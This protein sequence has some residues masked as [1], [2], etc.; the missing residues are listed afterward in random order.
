MRINER[1]RRAF[2]DSRPNVLNRVLEDCAPRKVTRPKHKKLSD[3][4]MQLIATAAS[5]AI[6]ISAA[7][8]GFLYYRDYFAG[9]SSLNGDHTDATLSTSPT[10]STDPLPT[11]PMTPEELILWIEEDARQIIC[12]GSTAETLPVE[13]VLDLPYPEQDQLATNCYVASATFA[14]Y[15]YALYYTPEGVLEHIYASGSESEQGYV[16]SSAVQAIALLDAKSRF[17]MDAGTLEVTACE[18]MQVDKPVYLLN[19]VY[20]SNTDLSASTI[21]YYIDPYTGQITDTFISNRELSRNEARDLAIDFVGANSFGVIKYFEITMYSQDDL[22]YYHIILEYGTFRYELDMDLYSGI[23]TDAVATEIGLRAEDNPEAGYIGLAS[24]QQIALAYCDI[25][26]DHV[27][28]FSYEFIDEHYRLSYYYYNLGDRLYECSVDATSGNV[29]DFR[30][31][32]Y[33]ASNMVTVL[34][35]RNIALDYVNIDASCVRSLSVGI[36][37]E[38]Q[39]FDFEVPDHEL[40]CVGIEYATVGYTITIDSQSGEI[41]N[42]KEY[43]CKYNYDE[44][45]SGVIGWSAARDIALEEVGITMDRMYYFHYQ[46]LS[47]NVYEV[48][49]Q[50]D[51][52]GMNSAHHTYRID[53]YTGEVLIDYVDPEDHLPGGGIGNGVAT[54]LALEYTGYTREEVTN[55]TW[56]YE[57]VNGSACYVIGFDASGLHYEVTVRYYLCSVQGSTATPVEGQLETIRDLALEHIDVALDEAYLL[58]VKYLRSG[59]LYSVIATTTVNSYQIYIPIS[60]DTVEVSYTTPSRNPEDQNNTTLI[61]WQSARDL[62]LQHLGITLEQVTSYRY[63]YFDN[64]GEIYAITVTV[65]NTE[66]TILMDAKSGTLYYSSFDEAVNSI[67]TVEELQDI[68]FQAAGLSEDAIQK[69]LEEDRFQYKLNLMGDCLAYGV[70]F[71]SDETW[72]WFTVDLFDNFI[73]QQGN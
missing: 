70:H 45:M 25:D 40:Y 50:T 28:G 56:R 31:P 66:Y 36:W 23:I 2:T 14:G 11:E 18:I 1:L 62:A 32:V 71:Y 24:A 47:G 38:G 39:T 59:N 67:I 4:T 52:S 57:V 73:I 7:T 30:F 49:L 13:V 41:L 63:F 60:M 44:S 53:A 27:L 35:A 54:D 20:R 64:N 17:D 65:D 8:G 5:I 10:G 55:I 43:T 42:C 19:I 69:I 34:E 72:Y 15:R 61:T 29:V 58:E 3:R 26:P 6:L 46:Y 68:T 48:M 12:P 16:S 21:G 33:G 51:W 37:S 22:L 9:Q